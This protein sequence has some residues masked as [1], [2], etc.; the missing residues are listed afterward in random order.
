MWIRLQLSEE[1]VLYTDLCYIPPKESKY[2]QGGV[3]GDIAGSSDEDDEE[4]KVPSAQSPYSVLLESIMQYS[5]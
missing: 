2:A 1:R 3:H 5:S 4:E